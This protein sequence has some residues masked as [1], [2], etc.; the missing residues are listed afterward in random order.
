MVP[1]DDSKAKGDC[2]V[3]E[4]GDP[5]DYSENG[6]NWDCVYPDYC[7]KE[8][9][10]QSPINIEW[11]KAIP[12]NKISFE[13]FYEHDINN[14]TLTLDGDRSIIRIDYPNEKQN[15]INVTNERAED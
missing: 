9:E 1:E 10:M 6:R 8:N 12:N 2:E 14:A 7:S 13:L 11:S 5:I 15:N 3:R 4:L